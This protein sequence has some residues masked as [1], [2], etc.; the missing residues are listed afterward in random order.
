MLLYKHTHHYH[1]TKLL[2]EKKRKSLS[3]LS[4]VLW[5]DQ[6]TTIAAFIHLHMCLK[7]PPVHTQR[8]KGE[9]FWEGEGKKRTYH[10]STF[11]SGLFSF[12]FKRKRT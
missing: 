2:C 11:Y 1:L 5:D 4:A 10:R 3:L 9:S 12:S 8:E 7:K 6:S